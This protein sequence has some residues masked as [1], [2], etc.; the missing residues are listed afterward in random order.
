[1][2]DSSLPLPAAPAAR[3][4]PEAFGHSYSRQAGL[5]VS[6]GSVWFVMV[7][8]LLIGAMAYQNHETINSFG[9]T[10]E[11]GFNGENCA[12]ELCLRYVLEGEHL[13]MQTAKVSSVSFHRFGLSSMAYIA[14]LITIVLG[15]VLIFDRV[16]DR[17]NNE[18]SASWQEYFVSFG[19]PFP[20]SLMVFLGTVALIV[21]LYFSG[22]GAPKIYVE[23]HPLYLTDPNKP[24]HGSQGL[25]NA[26]GSNI[27]ATD[28]MEH[29]RKRLP[30][31]A[32]QPPLGLEGEK[33]PEP[34]AAEGAVQ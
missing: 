11:S 23:T 7:L 24:A 10:S 28:V 15:S 29:R 34:G 22:P 14:A 1:M 9:S 13:R 32:K 20:G 26:F 8:L 5:Y 19:S 21:N 30:P 25:S 2:T 4:E 16:T 27:E 6:K 18:I 33:S 3:Q 12:T 31:A 17:Q